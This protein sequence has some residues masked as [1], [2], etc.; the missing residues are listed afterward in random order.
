[1]RK[2]PISSRRGD[3]EQLGDEQH[4]DL[5]DLRGSAIRRRKDGV[6]L[7]CSFDDDHKDSERMH[8]VSGQL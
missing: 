6:R 4:T 2:R 8:L 3:C 7:P 5:E 1:M